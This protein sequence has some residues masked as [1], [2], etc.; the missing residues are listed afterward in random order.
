MTSHRKAKENVIMYLLALCREEE[1]LN[2]DMKGIIKTLKYQISHH[3][4]IKILH[5]KNSTE[6]KMIAYK[7][8]NVI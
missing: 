4:I 7:K 8:N 2:S 1:F 6:D 3:K 5:V